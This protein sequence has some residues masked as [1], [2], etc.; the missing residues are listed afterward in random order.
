[1]VQ[2]AVEASRNV[3][4]VNTIPASAPDLSMISETRF[5]AKPMLTHFTRASR[6]DD[7]LDNLAA[8]LRDG[9]I[10]G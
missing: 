5:T 2:D 9:I 1:M 6:A 3:R 7:A 8:I 4:R 10:R